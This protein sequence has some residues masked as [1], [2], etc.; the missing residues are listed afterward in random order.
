MLV[1]DANFRI[2]SCEFSFV[3]D[4]NKSAIAITAL[5]VMDF[6]KFMHCIRVDL[7]GAIEI[8]IIH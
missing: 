2:H 6:C 5:I 4:I 8:N 7:G 3:H 1:C